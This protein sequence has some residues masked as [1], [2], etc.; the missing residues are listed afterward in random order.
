LK[1]VAIFIRDRLLHRSLRLA[2]L[3]DTPPTHR[4]PSMCYDPRWANWSLLRSWQLK[5]LVIGIM[6]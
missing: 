2:R 3:P 5:A 1:Q 6:A 4:N